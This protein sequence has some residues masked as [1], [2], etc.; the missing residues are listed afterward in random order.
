[1]T[2]LEQAGLK[3]RQARELFMLTVS[4]YGPGSDEALEALKAWG[5]AHNKMFELDVLAGIEQVW[6]EQDNA[7]IPS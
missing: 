3:A 2:Q 7:D 4:H 5:E 1:M 6:K